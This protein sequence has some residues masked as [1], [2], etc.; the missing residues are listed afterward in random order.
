MSRSM[1]SHHSSAMKSDSWLTPKWILQPLGKFDCD[2]CTPPTLPPEW[3]VAS[4]RLTKSED[5]LTH[6]WTGRVWL[7]PPFGSQWP[8]WVKRLADHGNGIALIAARTETAAFFEVVWSRAHAICFL[9]GRPHF[10]AGV[11]MKL[12]RKGKPSIMLKIGDRAPFNSGAPICLV[13]YGAKNVRALETSKLGETITLNPIYRRKPTPP[14]V[15]GERGQ[16]Q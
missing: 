14:A 9:R 13:A 15:G 16:A 7:N 3:C 2:P 10:H 5:G 1:G 8:K 6:P 4:Y 11:P 12:K